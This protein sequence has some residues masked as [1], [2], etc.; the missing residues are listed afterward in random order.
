MTES[1]RLQETSALCFLLAVLTS[2]FKSKAAHGS[3][4]LSE[5]AAREKGINA[6]GQRPHWTCRDLHRR[7]SGHFSESCRYSL[8]ALS[9]NAVVW[10]THSTRDFFQVCHPSGSRFCTNMALTR[11][12]KSAGSPS[13]SFVFGS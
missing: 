3:P 11:S 1:S 4:V 2:P 5:V 6:N 8:P 12:S 9:S 13:I 10:T 7:R